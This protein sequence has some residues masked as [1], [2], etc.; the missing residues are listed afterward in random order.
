MGCVIALV[1]MGSPRLAFLLAWLLTERVT[2][3]FENNVVPILGFI[4]LPWT[5][6]M[7]T[8]AYT[9][10][11]GVTGIGWLVVGLAFLADI[12]SYFS[13]LGARRSD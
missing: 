7:W 9:P 2:I 8:L 10:I 4:F 1:A 13:G 12:G 5:I 6:L 3:A 11:H